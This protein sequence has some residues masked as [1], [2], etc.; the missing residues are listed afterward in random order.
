MM[1]FQ[2]IRIAGFKSFLEPTEIQM[3]KGL[4]QLKK[5]KVLGY[6]FAG[7][8]G[9][10]GVEQTPSWLQNQAWFKDLA[11]KNKHIEYEEIKVSNKHSNLYN[12]E[13]Y[14]TSDSVS[15]YMS[16]ASSEEEVVEAKN[17]L[18]VMSSSISLRNQT[19]KALRDGYY[20]I[21]LGGDHS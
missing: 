2:S 5:I 17:I 1:N 11:N 21:V 15:E 7:G 19:Y 20:P 10:S 13:D 3:N 4:R 9:R 18:N 14:L 6:P 12:P 16:G 8:Q